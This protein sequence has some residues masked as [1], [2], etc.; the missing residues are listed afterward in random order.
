MKFTRF[1][2]FLCAVLVFTL[3]VVSFSQ[4]SVS[5]SDSSKTKSTA[6]KSTNNDS[7]FKQLIHDYYDAWN[8]GKP[9]NAARF[10]AKDP[11][12]VFFD[13]A[14]LKYTGWDEYKQGVQKNL[15]DNMTEGK[16]TPSD[17][18]KVTRHGSIAWTTLTFHYALKMKEGKSYDGD[19]RHTAIWEKR[20]GKW[21][22]VHEQLST[23]MN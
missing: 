3:Q 23:P 17:D 11:G 18:L 20:G 6:A 22:I 5:K 14:P 16:L 8:T 7:E 1:L 10:Y 15:F 2:I 13:L 9:D 21:L 4:S 12:L 19:G